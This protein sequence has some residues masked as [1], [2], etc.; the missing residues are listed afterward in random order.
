MIDKA[1][2]ASAWPVLRSPVTCA[3]SAL[4]LILLT[5]GGAHA[6]N[7]PPA[8]PPGQPNPTTE[9]IYAPWT[10]QCGKSQDA[11]GKQG[12]VTGMASFADT[13]FPMVSLLLVEPEGEKGIFRINV[14]EPVALP[15]GIRLVVDKEQPLSG[16]YLSCFQGACAALIE[17]TPDVITKM[18]SGKVL[19]IQVVTPDN[20]VA[21]FLLPLADFKKVHEGPASDPKVVAEQVKKLQ[22]DLQKRQ[23]A[24]VQRLQQQQQQQ[25][26]H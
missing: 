7:K 10:K 17:S 21:A 2:S 16:S 23:L 24:T 25:Q 19:A 6:Q 9:L 14:P 12:C 15:P 4:L 3:A 26:Q 22:E 11:S 20:Q 5:V 1:A 18:K 13:G 8:P